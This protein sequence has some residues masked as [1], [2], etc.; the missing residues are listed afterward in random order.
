MRIYRKYFAISVALLSLV[1]AW[2]VDTVLPAKILVTS[3]YAIPILICALYFRYKVVFA[4]AI[5]AFVVLTAQALR[6]RQDLTVM[7]FQELG[8]L[9]LCIL[10]ILLNRS[11]NKEARLK[12]N[13]EQTRQQ[14]EFLTHTVAHDIMQPITVSRLYAD[15]LT[16]N[17]TKGEVKEQLQKITRALSNIEELTKD[18]SEATRIGSGQMTL[19]P[20]EF[21]LVELLRHTLE[22]QQVT[23]GDHQLILDAPPQVIMVGDRGKI[24]RVFMNLLSNAI[25]YSPKGGTIKVKLLKT[26]DVLHITVKDNGI[27]MTKEE[28]ARIFQPFTRSY[29]GKRRIRG[30]GLGLYICRSI[31]EEHGGKI[32]VRSRRGNG[33]TFHFNLPINNNKVEE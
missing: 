28:Y 9:M 29:N 23:T 18:L 22:E 14:L 27:G 4:I 6:E 26:K 12:E 20:E 24:R 33:T 17:T 3:L 1:G 25:K 7:F 15:T 32:W 21:N 8:F 13:S 11:R 30:S 16:K 10:A 5:L 31:I 19:H 2:G